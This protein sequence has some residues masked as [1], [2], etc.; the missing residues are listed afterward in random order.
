MQDAR[1]KLT[2]KRTLASERLLSESVR[3][4]TA[5]LNVRT[6]CAYIVYRIFDCHVNSSQDSF[7]VYHRPSSYTLATA[8]F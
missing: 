2:F 8:A 7:M 1:M 3:P 6:S 4:E 5:R